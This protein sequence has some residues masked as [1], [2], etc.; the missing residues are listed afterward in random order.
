MPHSS[1]DPRRKFL[2]ATAWN[3]YSLTEEASLSDSPELSNFLDD[4]NEFLLS[5]TTN[6]ND[7]HFSN[8]V[9]KGLNVE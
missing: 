3:F 4:A 2:L 1:D 7:L 5:V 9:N 8:K 6:D